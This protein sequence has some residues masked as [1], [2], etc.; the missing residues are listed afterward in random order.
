M[1]IV[2]KAL[3]IAAI[4]LTSFSAS[5]T[6]IN[7][8]GVEW[9][10]DYVFDFNGVAGVIYQEIDLGTGNLSAYGRVTSL[11]GLG[12]ADL[13]PGCELTFHFGGYNLSGA[14]AALTSDFEYTGG[15]MN[16]G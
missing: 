6:L 5:A 2:K 16:F 4:V 8:G 13:C 1:N 14:D 15:W 9:D 11:N 12:A 10:P 7:V 3:A